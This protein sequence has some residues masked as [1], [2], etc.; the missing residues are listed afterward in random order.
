MPRLKDRQRP[1]PNGFIM[2]DAYSKW[3]APA[4]ATFEE[5][6]QGLMAYRQAHKETYARYGAPMDYE[7]ICAEV[8]AYNASLAQRMGWTD[9]YIGGPDPNLPAP[10]VT[11]GSLSKL[12]SAAASVSRLA[13]G[14]KAIKEWK[15]SEDPPVPAEHAERRAAVCVQ[16]PMNQGGQL[17]DFFTVPLAERIRKDMEDLHKR[18]LHTQ[19]DAAL[20]TCKACSCPLGLKVWIPTQFIAPTIDAATKDKLRQGNNCWIVSELGG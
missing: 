4:W 16:C 5:I 18:G 20:F 13:Q 17:T 3:K 19:F 15:A 12:A 11:G 8:D 14:Y 9:F 6:V 7:G 2:Y 10:Q 1:L